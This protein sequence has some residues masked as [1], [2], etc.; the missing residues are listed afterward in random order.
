MN[1]EA[2][3]QALIATLTRQGNSKLHAC[4]VNNIWSPDW[5]QIVFD[6]WA[7]TKHSESELSTLA[8]REF[9][10][11][12]LGLNATSDFHAFLFQGQ[13][14]T[15]MIDNI[16]HILFTTVTLFILAQIYGLKGPIVEHKRVGSES[17]TTMQYLLQAAK[18]M[19]RGQLS[20]NSVLNDR[21]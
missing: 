16:I 21:K 3:C 9:R 12:M 19:K 2:K 14:M 6:T 13:E 18:S 17:L 15:P 1:F 5:I 20:W 11:L 7:L 10:K 8:K 4:A